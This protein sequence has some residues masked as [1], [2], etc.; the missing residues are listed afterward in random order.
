[1]AGDIVFLAKASGQQM[2][3]LNVAITRRYSPLPNVK[4]AGRE[5]GMRC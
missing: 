1:M 3:C 2:K 5:G 4:Q